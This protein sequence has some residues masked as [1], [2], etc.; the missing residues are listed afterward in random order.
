M[1]KKDDALQKLKQFLREECAPR[2]IK[3]RVLRSDNGGEYIDGIL[4]SR[5]AS[6]TIR[7]EFSPPD[8]QSGSGVAENYWREMAR[9]VR[10]ILWD[11]QRGD[12][13]WPAALRMTDSIRNVLES[14]MVDG[15][16]IPE[17]QWTGESVDVAHFRVPLSTAWTSIEKAKRDG[18]TLGDR[19]MK[20]VLVGCARDSACYEVRS[21]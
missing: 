10:S 12:E 5:C 1:K 21:V 4:Q 7:Q 14:D 16:G 17:V 2:G 8:C 9:Y 20:G 15:S 3:V 18:G 13:W 19:R 11:Q 6:H